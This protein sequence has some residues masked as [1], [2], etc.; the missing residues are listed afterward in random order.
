MVGLGDA[1]CR[2]LRDTRM[3]KPIPLGLGRCDTATEDNGGSSQLH[4]L[5][6]A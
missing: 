6:A 2:R 4:A 5:R 1:R 3:A